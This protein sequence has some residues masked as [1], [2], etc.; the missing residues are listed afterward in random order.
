[1]KRPGAS[2]NDPNDAGDRAG[3]GQHDAVSIDHEAKPATSS[4]KLG[5]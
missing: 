1:M 5:R 3:D 2:S 4:A